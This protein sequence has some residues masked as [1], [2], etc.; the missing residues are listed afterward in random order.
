MAIY[1]MLTDTGIDKIAQTQGSNGMYIEITRWVGAFY[2]KLN[3]YYNVDNIDY[4]NIVKYT[5]T[6]DLYPNAQYV[7]EMMLSMKDTITQK[8]QN[9]IKIVGQK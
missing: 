8:E 7:A 9:K 1:T 4:T 5:H 2:S 6:T 3:A